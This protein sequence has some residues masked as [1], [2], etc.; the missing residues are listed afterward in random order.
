[1]FLTGDPPSTGPFDLVLLD[2]P[3]DIDAAEL[4]RVLAG[5]GPDGCLTRAGRW[6]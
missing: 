1:M 6:S 3:Y 2:P 4:E 5:L